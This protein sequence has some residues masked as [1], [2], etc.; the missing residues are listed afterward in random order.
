MPLFY[1]YGAAYCTVQAGRSLCFFRLLA[2]SLALFCVCSPAEAGDAFI[3]NG[4]YI[5]R[6]TW[7]GLAIGEV[8]LEMREEEASHRVSVHV[9]TAG[10]AGLF[11]PHE[12]RTTVEGAGQGEF[13]AR[14]RVY[15]SHYTSRGKPRHVRLTYTA[16]GALTE[17]VV[18]PPDN[19]AKR[20][21]VPDEQK[22]ATLDPM[23]YI[24]AVRQALREVLAKEE[25]M[26]SLRL[27]DGRR[28]MDTVWRIEGKAAITYADTKHP[29]IQVTGRRSAVTGFTAKELRKL[30]TESALS[31]YFS[32][33]EL[34]PLR[35]QMP[36]ALGTLTAELV[37]RCEVEVP[38]SL[39]ESAAKAK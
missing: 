28:L 1:S 35:L 30:K 3:M 38:C 37:K 24:L 16:G 7:N 12:S 22:R 32:E 17:T 6:A 5:Y 11:A 10:L 39:S 9:R 19:P 13:A 4:I 26:F 33:E 27:F 34:L 23:S 21:P 15:E 20:P 25:R 8:A 31:V 36:L 2:V 29:V 14:P 18:E